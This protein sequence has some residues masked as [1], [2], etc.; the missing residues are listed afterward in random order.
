MNGGW[1]NLVGLRTPPIVDDSF[2]FSAGLKHRQHPVYGFDAMILDTTWYRGQWWQF[3]EKAFNV[4][5]NMWYDES[6]LEGYD[7]D[8]NPIWKHDEL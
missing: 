3:A 1:L 8:G 5:D 2:T 6:M 7:D 4:D